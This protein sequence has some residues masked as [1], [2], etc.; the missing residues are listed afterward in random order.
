MVV[1]SCPLMPLTADAASAMGRIN[2]TRDRQA[3]EASRVGCHRVFLL[4][5]AVPVCRKGQFVPTEPAKRVSPVK[6]ICGSAPS[7]DK[8]CSIGIRLCALACRRALIFSVANV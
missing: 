4:G 2:K 5:L 7:E 3:A 8:L 6:T 1:G